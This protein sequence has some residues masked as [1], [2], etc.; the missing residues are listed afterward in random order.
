M[1]AVKGQ[2]GVCVPRGCSN[3]KLNRMWSAAGGGIVS[4]PRARGGC[5]RGGRDGQERRSLEVTEGATVLLGG[6]GGEVGASD[7]GWAVSR[8]AA[9]VPRAWEHA[10]VT[11]TLRA[12]LTLMP[13]HISVR[14]E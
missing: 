13:C 7:A 8:T 5:G 10:S 1:E 6:S 9:P 11:D 2:H 14:E 3:E 12:F 4:R